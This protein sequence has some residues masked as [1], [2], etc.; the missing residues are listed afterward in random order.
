MAY[1]NFNA[2]DDATELKTAMKGIGCKK[3]V[4]IDILANRNNAQRVEIGIAFK[5]LYGKV[6]KRSNRSRNV[7]NF[8][9]FTYES[10]RGNNYPLNKCYIGRRYIK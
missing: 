6:I 3:D 8:T 7:F 9:S 5:T 2:K 4:V 10:S 1:Q